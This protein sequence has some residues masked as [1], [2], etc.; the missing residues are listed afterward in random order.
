MP[1]IGE[2]H[3]T[4]HEDGGNDE[5][6]ISGLTGAVEIVDTPA[7]GETTKGI[8]SNW[9]YDHAAN[10]DAHG[11]DLYPWTIFID[12]FP[13]SKSNINWDVIQFYESAL[14]EAIKESSGAQNDEI[15]WDIVL[16]AGTWSIEL[17]HSKDTAKGIFSI[18]FD[19]VEKGTIDAYASS[20]SY[21]N[22][23]SATGIAVPTTKKIELKLK[24]TTKNA[25]SSEY[26]GSLSGVRLM[27]TA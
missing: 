18:Q 14:H 17:I 20:T 3:H 12:V 15:T 11:N 21:I 7:D 10:P 24:M 8:T 4:T 13:T 25:A 1:E 23:S 27:R 16:A 22:R 6:N 9:A 26:Y 2:R 19:S 5:I